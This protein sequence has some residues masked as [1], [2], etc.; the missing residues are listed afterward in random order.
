MKFACYVLVRME[1]PVLFRLVHVT[2]PFGYRLESTAGSRA[3]QRCVRIAVENC[4]SM[5]SAQ[6]RRDNEFEIL[7]HNF[8][9]N[10]L[11]CPPHVTHV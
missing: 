10:H 1:K 11:L 9:E 4:H 3:K 7:K 6:A 5:R 2:L 8:S